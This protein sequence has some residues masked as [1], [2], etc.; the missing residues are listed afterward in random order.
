MINLKQINLQPNFYWTW[1]VTGHGPNKWGEF[2]FQFEERGAILVSNVVEWTREAGQAEQ[3]EQAE[4]RTAE[5]A[6]Q[7]T[8]AA[9][10]EEG[11]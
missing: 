1:G 5:Q 7:R 6:E 10:V 8:H 2:W 11:S 3:A 4:Q 9:S